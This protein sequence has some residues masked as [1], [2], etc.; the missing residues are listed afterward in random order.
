MVITATT[1]IDPA[2]QSPANIAK[3]FLR[4][5]NEKIPRFNHWGIFLVGY[6]RSAYGRSVEAIDTT[7][8]AIEIHRA[9][10]LALFAL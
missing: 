6:F 5:K 7:T 10:E 2:T 1:V 3:G 4:Q 9:T 8:A